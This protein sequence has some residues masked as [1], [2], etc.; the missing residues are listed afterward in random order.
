VNPRNGVKRLLRP[1]TRRLNARI[2]RR[3]EQ[4]VA[5][6]VAPL[7]EHFA[8][9]EETATIERDQRAAEQY[10]AALQ[11]NQSAALQHKL[12]EDVDRLAGD[13]EV[14]DRYV[15]LI[16]NTVS[17]Q[18]AVHRDLGRRL[19]H[20]EREHTAHLE[21]VSEAIK[22]LEGR[23]ELVRKEMLFE[24]RYGAA[25]PE[26]PI[27]SPHREVAPKVV[28]QDKL[29]SMGDDIRLN[30][31]A[32]HIALSQYLNVDARELPDI[33]VVADVRHLPFE[34]G[35]VAEIFSAHMLEHFPLEELRRTLLP[36][37]ISMLREGGRFVAV[38]PD[39]GKMVEE[40]AAGRMP[41]V[42]FMEVIY[43][44]QE[45]EGD[46]HFAGFTQQ[47]LVSLLED[48]GLSDVH[49]VEAGRRNGM[50]YEMEVEA[51]ARGLGVAVA[52]APRDR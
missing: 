31:G 41:A 22:Y 48:A 9:Q 23:L 6:A 29:K 44:G 8:S 27:A 1:V 39:V 2:D 17:S 47:L 21:R 30:L 25:A 46:F 7:R 34:K 15:P 10:R 45:Y 40:L 24:V 37:W 19:G 32:G 12:V 51:V 42:E 5:A 11:R 28:A 52:G 43:G 50:C 33:D 36:Y 13:V 20:I 18:N 14:L 38:V 49:I 26:T 3:S 35:E 4:D 16:L